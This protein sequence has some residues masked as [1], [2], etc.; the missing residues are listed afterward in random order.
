MVVFLALTTA[1]WHLDKGYVAIA[2]L[3][4][5][6][7]WALTL[8]LPTTGGGAPVLVYLSNEYAAAG[9]AERRT[10]FATVA[11]GLIAENNTPNL[12]GVLTAA[13][14]LLMSL[15]MLKGVVSRPIAYLG[16]ATGGTGVLRE[17]FRPV[18]GVGY[19]VYGVLLLVWFV[20]IGWTL[21][22]IGRSG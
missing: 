9:S 5:I 19:S 6:S 14:I 22:R 4:G 21:H 10:A 1:L 11:E 15:V 12:V 18:L 3:I 20:V 8:A 7:A 17:T 16:I 13:S 2:G